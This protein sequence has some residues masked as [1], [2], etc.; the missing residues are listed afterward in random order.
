MRC[1]SPFRK[2]FRALRVCGIGL[3]HDDELVMKKLLAQAGRQA[4]SLDSQ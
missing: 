3:S 4:A 1:F 2:F